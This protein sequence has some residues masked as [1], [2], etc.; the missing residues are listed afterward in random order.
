MAQTQHDA[1]IDLF[2]DA[3]AAKEEFEDATADLQRAR[4]R[5]IEA[6]D[7]VDLDEDVATVIDRHIRQ[8]EFERARR[9]FRDRVER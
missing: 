1:I 5:L 4:R 2:S 3:T 8:N 9:E 6:L 7:Q